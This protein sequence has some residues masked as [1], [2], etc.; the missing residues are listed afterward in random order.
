[1]TERA[2]SRHAARGAAPVE[3][4]HRHRHR[5]RQEF[6]LRRADGRFRRFLTR[7]SPL[8]DSGGNVTQWFGTNTDVTELVEAQEALREADR[9]KTEFLGMLS[10]ELRNPLVPIR[11]GPYLLDRDAWRRA[12][13]VRADRW[14]EAGPYDKSRSIFCG[15]QGFATW[16]SNPAS[17]A[18]W[19][20]SDRA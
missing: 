7:A 20:S 18:R 16:P 8:K 12:L 10:H 3:G 11:H 13:P 19:T 5:V 2:R 6:P 9:R 17:I 15:S 4:A 1:V 14:A